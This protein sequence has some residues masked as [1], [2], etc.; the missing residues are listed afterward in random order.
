MAQGIR[1][2]YIPCALIVCKILS[3]MGFD[4]IMEAADSLGGIEDIIRD[5]KGLSCFFKKF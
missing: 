4:D 5:A 3:L 2:P 1:F